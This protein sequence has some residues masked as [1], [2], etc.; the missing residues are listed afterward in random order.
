MVRGSERQSIQISDNEYARITIHEK[1][2]G[3]ERPIVRIHKKKLWLFLKKFA[4]I[5][6]NHGIQRK[7]ETLVFYVS[8]LQRSG[9]SKSIPEVDV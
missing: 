1:I 7:E 5:I 8:R 6:T 2:R 9:P 3:L 4:S